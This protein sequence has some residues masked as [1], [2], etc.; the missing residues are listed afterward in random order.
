M[1]QKFGAGCR[2]W[3]FVGDSKQLK[4]D[5][6]CHPPHLTI[7]P[8]PAPESRR[9]TSLTIRSSFF[10]WL[11]HCVLGADYTYRLGH[12]W[13]IFLLTYFPHFVHLEL[14]V[15]CTLYKIR[16]YQFKKLP[17]NKIEQPFY[18]AP[19]NFMLWFLSSGLLKNRYRYF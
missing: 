16:L 11:F 15:L 3:L 7:Y 14:L 2:C 19:P 6:T 13:L 17:R 1:L 9:S 12:L 5:N 10:L 18:A 8:P 4:G